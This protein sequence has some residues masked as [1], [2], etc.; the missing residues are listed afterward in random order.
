ME[1]LTVAEISQIF[2]IAE[3]SVRALLFQGRQRLRRQLVAKGLVDD[4]L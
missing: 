1:D 2:Q 3:G 4:E